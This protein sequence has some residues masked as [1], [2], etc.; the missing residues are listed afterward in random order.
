MPHRLSTKTLL[1]SQQQSSTSH[2]SRHNRPRKY[3]RLHAR[4]SIK[5]LRSVK[6]SYGIVDKPS[7]SAGGAKIMLIKMNMSVPRNPSGV[8]T[9]V[10]AQATW[11][12]SARLGS[13]VSPVSRLAISLVIVPNPQ[14]WHSTLTISPTY[15][16]RR[17][18]QN[19]NKS[20]KMNWYKNS[21]HLV[22]IHQIRVNQMKRQKAKQV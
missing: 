12:M 5:T 9:T 3:W 22:W 2:T 18:Y 17:Q 10:V 14:L 16:A 21:A 6:S 7:L 8:A 13:N 11:K 15:S 4:G 20:L 1:T 19:L